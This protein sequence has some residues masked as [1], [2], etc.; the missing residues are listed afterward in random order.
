[1]SLMHGVRL[2]LAE[3]DCTGS[4]HNFFGHNVAALVRLQQ[5]KRV[6]GMHPGTIAKPANAAVW[7]EL[8]HPALNVD[9]EGIPRKLRSPMELSIR[10]VQQPDIVGVRIPR[11]PHLSVNDIGED[12][13]AGCVDNNFV[14]SK[15]VCLLRV[16]AI[17]PMDVL[18]TLRSVSVDLRAAL[19]GFD[20][21]V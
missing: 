17:R 8:M 12:L 11:R 9:T 5:K 13:L 3:F 21:A 16:K 6:I 1:M 15:Q 10:A 7:N 4:L 20:R 19:V 2:L 14:V 18:R